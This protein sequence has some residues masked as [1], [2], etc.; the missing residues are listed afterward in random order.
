MAESKY[1]SWLRLTT[2][3][4]LLDK[5]KLEWFEPKLEGRR[6]GM[7]IPETIGVDFVNAVLEELNAY[8]EL[9]ETS[10]SSSLLG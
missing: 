9:S 6:T 2:T 8:D 3:E 5:P 1:R 10:K 4:C 7:I